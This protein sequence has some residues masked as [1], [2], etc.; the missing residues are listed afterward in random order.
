MY[1]QAARLAVAGARRIALLATA[2]V[3]TIL[4]G[5]ALAAPSGSIRHP[6]AGHAARAGAIRTSARAGQD[7]LG[8]VTAE[9]WPVVF[10]I[11][12]DGRTLLLASIG[13]DMHCTS[14]EHYST[15]DGWRKAPIGA[16]GRLALDGTMPLN[17]YSDGSSLSESDTVRATVSAKRDRLSGTWDLHDTWI[18]ANGTHDSCDSGPVRFTARA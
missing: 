12:K 6:A 10:R 7:V 17:T 14:G 9:G 3:L 5:V 13:V 11:S 18:A 15:Y 8:G 1:L 4:G 2:I 16:H